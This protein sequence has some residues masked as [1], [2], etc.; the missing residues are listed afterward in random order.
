MSATEIIA[1]FKKLPVS[2]QKTVVQELSGFLRDSRTK[3]EGDDDFSKLADEM[4]A[5]N[6]EL[7]RKLAS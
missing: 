6:A 2:E 4:F 1:E 3:T 7:F 5:M